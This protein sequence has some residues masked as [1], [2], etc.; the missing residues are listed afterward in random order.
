MQSVLLPW[1]PVWC[2]YQHCPLLPCCK[3]PGPQPLDCPGYWMWY[4]PK[5][6]ACLSIPTIS[7]NHSIAYFLI[8]LSIFLLFLTSS[9]GRWQGCS[10]GVLWCC[11]L[12]GFGLEERREEVEWSTITARGFGLI[13]FGFVSPERCL[14]CW[15]CL[16]APLLAFGT[17]SESPL[18][19]TSRTGH[20]WQSLLPF[21]IWLSQT[22]CICLIPYPWLAKNKA[23]QV[24]YYR[25]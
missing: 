14:C 21:W 2:H 9:M 19:P 18:C 10:Y 20:L 25:K 22:W 5:C 16:R 15:R 12:D 8:M 7:F 4:W 1:I 13:W 17:A 3:N 6:L 11:H 24:I 23:P